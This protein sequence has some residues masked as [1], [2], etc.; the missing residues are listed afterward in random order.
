MTL[1]QSGE[2]GLAL[3][4]RLSLPRYHIR[5][6]LTNFAQM[7]GPSHLILDIGSGRLAP[8]RPL[9]DYERYVAIDYFEWADVRA[10]ASHLPFASESASVILSTEVFEHLPEPVEALREVR[11]VLQ[12]H[13]YFILTVP[14][15]WGVHDYVDYQRWTERGLTKFLNEAGYEVLEFRQRGGIFSMLGCMITQIPRQIFGSLSQQ[16]HWWTRGAYALTWAVTLPIPWL[17]SFF[18]YFDRSKDFTLGYSVL[19]R[20][21]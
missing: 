21:Q 11:R 9:F 1:Q 18:D 8:Y 12:D 10:D 6:H 15:V 19:C 20:K 7:I 16:S 4:R 13:G 2:W 14:L 3:S 5:K 17:A